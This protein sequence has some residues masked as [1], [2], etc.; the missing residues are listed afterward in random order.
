MLVLILSACGTQSAL[1]PR[2][3]IAQESLPIN[4]SVQIATSTP[5]PAGDSQPDEAHLQWIYALVAPFPTVTDGVTFDE[6]YLAWTEGT[7]PA[8][9]SGVPL[10]MDES[11]LAALTALWDE[12]APDAVWIVARDRLLEKAWSVAPAWAIVPF[13]VLEPKWKVLTVDGQSPIRKDFD[14][15]TYP[16]VASIPVQ[17]A[18]SSQRLAVSD[19][20]SNYD[21]SK[22]TTIIM[23]GVTA[24]VRAT[25]M[26]ME[27][28]GTTYPGEKI[29]DLMREA[30]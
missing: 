26:T 21:P 29:R 4:S 7:A 19:Q 18:T 13:E 3:Q 17:S 20:P 27:L 5:A 14:L 10:L 9:F 25:A 24:L 30:D 6:L 1:T 23:T 28:K 2:P 15:S 12:P 16:L 8:A 11:T 22:M